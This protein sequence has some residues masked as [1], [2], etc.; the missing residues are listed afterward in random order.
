MLVLKERTE[1][2]DLIDSDNGFQMSGP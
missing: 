1:E 2:H